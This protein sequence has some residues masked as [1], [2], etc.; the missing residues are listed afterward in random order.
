MIK[1]LIEFGA[2]VDHRDASGKTP[3]IR[4]ISNEHMEVAKL[5]IKA[6]ANLELED[7]NGHTALNICQQ[8]SKMRGNQKEIE[9]LIINSMKVE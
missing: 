5:L 9:Q 1:A 8:V 2:N 4:A 3:L 6:G 7:Q